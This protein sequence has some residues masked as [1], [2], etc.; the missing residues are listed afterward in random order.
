[1]NQDTWVQT[2]TLTLTVWDTQGKPYPTQGL[3]VLF[4]KAGWGEDLDN[5]KVSISSHSPGA[6]DCGPEIVNYLHA[7]IWPDTCPA[8][9]SSS[10]LREG[11]PPSV[12]CTWTPLTASLWLCS[13]QVWPSTSRKQPWALGFTLH[14]GRTP[15][16]KS[17]VP[18]L[19]SRR[20][21]PRAPSTERKIS[22]GQC[23]QAS[24]FK[25]AAFGLIPMIQQIQP[26]QVLTPT[27]QAFSGQ[28]KAPLLTNDACACKI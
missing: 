7:I 13:P 9:V 25:W 15:A 16:G 17:W 3:H 18:A 21:S 10:T 28:V 1:M 12:W 4:C 5:W 19:T 24:G 8:F 22:L 23:W 20:V 14:W 6:Q 2:P 11:G 26:T 27:L